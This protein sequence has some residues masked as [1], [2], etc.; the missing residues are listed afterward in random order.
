MSAY[1][2]GT[3][4]KARGRTIENIC[5]SVYGRTVSGLSR[6][7]ERALSFHPGYVELRLDYLH[8][9][10]ENLSQLSKVGRFEN[11]IFTFRAR[12]EGG[13]SRVSDWTRSRVLLE[14]ISRISPPFVD[15]EIETL[16]S[17]PE[18]SKKLEASRLKL[19]ASSH[20]FKRFGSLSDHERLVLRTVERYSPK[21]VKIVR[22]AT[23]FPD[24]LKILALYRISRK[25]RPTKLVAF[26]SG[27]LG[28]F[29]RIACVDLGSPFTFASLSNKSTAPGQLDVE[30]M[31]AILESLGA[32]QR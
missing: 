19:I 8:S 23:D 2:P 4:C 31:K 6:N 7:L 13:A 32:K 18:I 26:C 29:S 28:L 20:D 22:K 14:I 9:L 16:D 25:I 1:S 5:V 27:P 11:E 15:V 21:I 30:S 10:P 24:N 17:F 3:N 12:S